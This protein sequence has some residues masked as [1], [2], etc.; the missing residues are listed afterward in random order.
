MCDEWL[1]SC[2]RARGAARSGGGGEAMRRV[3]R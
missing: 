1:L 2:P 3:R